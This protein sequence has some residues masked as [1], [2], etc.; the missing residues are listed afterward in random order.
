MSSLEYKLSELE[1]K[2]RIEKDK[3]ADIDE[4][5]KLLDMEY[6]KKTISKSDYIDEAVDLFSYRIILESRRNR[7]QKDLDDFKKG[8]KSLVS[9][10][11]LRREAINY[12]K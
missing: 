11:T 2:L 6:Q 10:R 3:L 8:N 1:L 12:G 4:A 7:A 5:I 9:C